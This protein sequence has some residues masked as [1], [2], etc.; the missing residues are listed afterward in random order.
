MSVTLALSA[1]RNSGETISESEFSRLSPEAPCTQMANPPRRI[2]LYCRILD[3]SPNPFPIDIDVNLTVAHLKEEIVKKNP[4]TFANVDAYKLV[5][6]KVGGFSP[7]SLIY[8]HEIL[9]GTSYF[10]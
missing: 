10:H 1:T 2:T 9:S 4:G 8:A 7:L 3:E 6:W 5:L